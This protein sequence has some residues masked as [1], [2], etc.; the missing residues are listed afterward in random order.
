MG[1]SSNHASPGRRLAGRR[2]VLW[3]AGAATAGLLLGGL[4]AMAWQRPGTTRLRDTAAYASRA[5]P[6]ARLEAILAGAVI[7]AENDRFE[8]ARQRASDFF[9]GF[10]RYLAPT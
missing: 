10:Q 1:A 3:I 7:E 4:V 5:L 9:T 6:A 8:L 2:A